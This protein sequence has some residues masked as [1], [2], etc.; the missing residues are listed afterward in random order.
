V[1]I[2]RVVIVLALLLTAG[3]AGTRAERVGAQGSIDGILRR[4]DHPAYPVRERAQRA[5]EGYLK[6]GVTR[7]KD[8]AAEASLEVR[9]RVGTALRAREDSSRR[10]HAPVRPRFD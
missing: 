4:L 8:V 5:L 10:P 3:P 1:R 2:A 9:T 7:P 6:R